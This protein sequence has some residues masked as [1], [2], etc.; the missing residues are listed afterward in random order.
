M[1][2]PAT[3]APMTTMARSDI[4]SA[5]PRRCRAGEGECIEISSAVAQRD[6]NYQRI[7]EVV[8]RS[9]GHANGTFSLRFGDDIDSR[10]LRRGRRDGARLITINEKQARIGG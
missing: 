9:A 1:K 8:L 7:A 3:I 10:H 6:R 5:T 4:A 2:P